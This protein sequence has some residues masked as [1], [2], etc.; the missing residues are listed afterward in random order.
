V[1]IRLKTKNAFDPVPLPESKDRQKTGERSQKGFSP[2]GQSQPFLPTADR[3]S[4]TKSNRHP[5]LV[6]RPESH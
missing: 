3:A 5:P 4:P 1:V 6:T 2:K